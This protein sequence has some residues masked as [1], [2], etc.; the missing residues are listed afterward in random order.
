MV[1]IITTIRISWVVKLRHPPAAQALS[2]KRTSGQ[3]LKGLE[4]RGSV[5]FAGSG[6]ITSGSTVR[7]PS[8]PP[9]ARPTRTARSAIATVLALALAL[10]ASL[11]PT[12]AWAAPGDFTVDFSASESAWIGRAFSYDVSI[13]AEATPE[14][15]ASGIVL[16]AQLPE[17]VEFDSVPVGEASPVASFTYDPA[18]RTVQFTLKELT[19]PL[20]GFSFAVNQVNND[21]KV[22][23][24]ELEATLEA[25]AGP[26]ALPPTQTASTTI[27]GDNLY[28]PTKTVE[29]LVGSGNRSATYYF[30]AMPTKHYGLTFTSWA[31]RLTDVLPAGAIVT[32]HSTG[33]GAWT[34]TANADGT[35]TAVWEREGVLNASAT[36]IAVPARQIW[37]TVNY[38]VES[39]P[40]FTTPP[41]NVV[42]LE[43]RDFAGTWHTQV[44]ATAQPPEVQTGTDV[45]VNIVKGTQAGPDEMTLKHGVYLSNFETAASYISNGAENLQS[46][47]VTDGASQSPENAAVFDHIDVNRLAVN[48]NGSLK[49]QALPYT[50]EYTSSAE[51]G[52]WLAYT[53]PAA[54][55]TANDLR[56][57][58][59]TVGSQSFP[60]DGYTVGIELAEGAHLTGWRVVVSPDDDTSVS[61]GA[62]VRVIPYGQPSITSLTDGAPAP[63]TLTNTAVVE[64][65]TAEGDLVAES[66]ALQLVFADRVPITTYL[67][68]PTTL[69]V[70]GAGTYI[71][72]IANL[73]PSGRAYAGSVLRVILPAGVFYDPAQ[74]VTPRTP[75]TIVSGVPIPAAGDGMHVSTSSVDIAGKTHQVVEIHI[76]SLTSIRTAGTVRSGVPSEDGFRYNVPVTVQP[77]A[78]TGDGQNVPVTSW[79]STDDL[80]YSHV[81]MEFSPALYGPDEHNFNPSLDQIAKAQ[82]P[83]LFTAA[84]GLLIGKLVRTDAAAPW[85]T[86]AVVGT[87]GTAEWQIYA[88]NILPNPVDTLE[89][90]DKLPSVTDSRGSTFQV[91]LSGPVTGAPAG[92]TVEYSVD[93]TRVS[94]GTWTTDPTGATAV[95]VNIPSMATGD[96]A[97]MVVP[98]S[99]PQG[100]LATDTATNDVTATGTYQGNVR[101]FV[102][103]RAVITP[104][105]SPAFEFVKTTN[106]VNYDQAPGA[107]V[108]E[109]SQVEWTYT[110]TNTGNTI[111][112]NL[113]VTDEYVDGAG[114]TG[115]LEPGSA[116]QGQLAPGQSRT[117]TATAQATAGQYENTATA[118]AVAVDP[119]GISLDVQPAAANA[120][121]WYFGGEAGMVI[122]K[123]T[124]DQDL[125]SAPGV[126]VAPGSD[127]GWT[128]TVENTGNVDLADVQVTDIDSDG[129]TVFD[130]VISDLAVG[131]SV[132]LSATGTAIEGQYENTVTATTTHPFD[133]QQQIVA[134]DT[135]WYF[136]VIAGLD[137]T[138]GASAT[139]TGAFTESVTV[140]EG[141]SVWWEI[142]VTN[143]G[144]SPLTD[145]AVVDPELE[146]NFAIDSL[147]AGQSRS[148]VLH[149]EELTD[150]YTNTVQASATTDLAQTV[151]ASAEATVTVDENPIEPIEPVD[152]VEPTEPT[153][154]TQTSQTEAPAASNNDAGSSLAST[155]ATVA[156]TL[157]LAAALVFIGFAAMGIRRRGRQ[158]EQE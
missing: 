10:A 99:I 78:Y 11:V 2:A 4:R 46:L 142:I 7:T 9:L 101:S 47:T 129:N 126:S 52:T 131:Q 16:T 40:D 119:A 23:N 79:A 137:V 149:D 128:Y 98:T 134:A 49:S 158:S 120:S 127:V 14:A 111:L 124:Q 147:E 113:V 112:D 132:E 64:A 58:V 5:G 108:A 60:A 117:F 130:E 20:S 1:V 31:Q 135:S 41:A 109:G 54:I 72:T 36:T 141:D 84:G 15:P 45:S 100:L 139:E 103:N 115:T 144:N 27:L 83:T 18:T 110:V 102:S 42:G 62:E 92:S 154:P 34:T 93:A 28:R 85:S 68:G 145:V 71:A 96:E 105:A 86:S 29:T 70:G 136:G 30:D 24:Q 116:V 12:S 138:K 157:V 21:A 76:D 26:A 90:F 51:P 77:S 156:G 67:T 146:E 97:T 95:R 150:G 44:T 39:F 61:G 82:H 91:T 33:L 38:P 63:A 73:D 43:T 104:E 87:P 6:P 140:P 151:E 153:E 121:S 35:T 107:Q 122:T 32:A 88:H 65:V 59:Q 94:E 143:T 74:G 53:P 57:V 114:A 22:E 13:S 19:S 123:L 56:I 152:P 8:S 125:T 106:G 25:T 81:E 3:A 89:I 69:Q 118:T 17:G 37:L 148:F 133:E 55:T 50:L 66:D 75:S 155:G 48:F 80:E